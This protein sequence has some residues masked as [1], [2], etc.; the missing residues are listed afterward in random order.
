MSKSNQITLS[1][2]ELVALQ[3]KGIEIF[4]HVIKAINEMKLT[5]YCV[6][7]TAIGA[8]KYQGFIP[9]D[10]D[11]DIAM[12][13]EDYMKFLLN[14]HKYLPSHLFIS[15]CFTEKNYFGS[16]AKV[17]D[18]NTSYFDIETAKF[19]TCHGAFVDIFP[20]DG[21]ASPTRFERF[22]KKIYQGRIEFAQKKNKSFGA[23]I[24]GFFASLLC[25]FKSLNKCCQKREH[26]LMRYKI[27]DCEKVYNRIMVFDKNIF[28]KPSSGKFAGLDVL[29]PERL[30]DYLK[31]CYG[32]INKEMPKDKQIPHH[33]AL[34]IDLNTPYTNY[35]YSHGRMVK[36]T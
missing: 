33:F 28:G 27:E 8:K 10:D 12:P 1:K 23:N 17:R 15:S 31:I 20:I 13:R 4:G 24:K 3:Q 34:L 35:V 30:D 26:L 19:D 7:G 2:D 21:Y 5:Y 9:W 25:C 11:I 6:G 36:R 14:G 32:D 16:V 29:L 22:L 18:I